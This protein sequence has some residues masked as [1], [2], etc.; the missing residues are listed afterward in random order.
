MRLE[1]PRKLK[2][3][4]FVSCDPRWELRQRHQTCSDRRE[5]KAEWRSANQTPPTT[6]TPTLLRLTSPPTNTSRSYSY[7]DSPNLP[8]RY[9]SHSERLLISCDS[10]RRRNPKNSHCLIWDDHV[11][12]NIL[13]SSSS[14]YFSIQGHNVILEEQLHQKNKKK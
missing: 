4:P 9:V 5:F 3:E 10:S 8:E 2:R 1:I 14:C 7:C 11:D 12:R 6:T 13:S